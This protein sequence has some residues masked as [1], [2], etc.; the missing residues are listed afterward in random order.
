[1]LASKYFVNIAGI[2]P[3]TSVVDSRDKVATSCRETSCL[4]EERAA[5]AME[6]HHRVPYF[7]EQFSAALDRLKERSDQEN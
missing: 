5:G 2:K 3:S 6:L 1:M 4:Q 7:R